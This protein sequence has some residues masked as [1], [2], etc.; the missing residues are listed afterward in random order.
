MDIKESPVCQKLSEL[1]MEA[2]SAKQKSK[3]NGLLYS[4]G[5]VDG[6]FSDINLR[7]F[8][9][10]LPLH[11]IILVANRYFNT[12]LTGAWKEEGATEL[13]LHFDD[14]NITFDGCMFVF[15]KMYG[16]EADSSTLPSSITGLIGILAASSYFGDE[17]TNTR[18]ISIL[19]AKITSSSINDVVCLVNFALEF[20]YE[21]SDQILESAFSLLCRDY[22]SMDFPTREQL[23]SEIDLDF[24]AQVICSDCFYCPDEVFHILD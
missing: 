21:H 24:M 3:E 1:A 8:N 17:S 4:T 13:T 20:S 7:I 11:R 14:P 16:Y 6:R 12:M 18:I 23:F 15:A 10:I 5:F 22:Y 2:P 19:L 9:E